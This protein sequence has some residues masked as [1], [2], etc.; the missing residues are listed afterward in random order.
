M[1]WLTSN[2]LHDLIQSYSDKATK[3]AFIGIFSMDKLPQSLPQLPILLI[4]NTD[5]S[6]LP[7]E[8]WKAVFISSE[9]I[10]EV[11]DSLALP[12][13]IF[14]HR[15]MNT[16]SWKWTVSKRRIQNPL[17]ATC[18]AFTLYFV[19]NRLNKKSM[20]DC[21]RIFTNNLHANDVLMENFVDELRK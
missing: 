6:N 19:L 4:V 17:S 12:I 2:E 18:G 7:G 8:H 14:L 21:I 5:S 9:K 1:S 16:F 3:Q 20:S 10:G 13:E 11:F 15:W